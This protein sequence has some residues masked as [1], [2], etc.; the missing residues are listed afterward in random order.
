MPVIA[1]CHCGGTRIELPEPPAGLTACTCTYCTKSGGLWGYYKP[2]APVI[3][4]DEFGAVYSASD[5]INRHHFCVRCGCQTYGDSPDWSLDGA[6]GI[7][8]QRKFAINARLL[9][10]FALFRALPVTEIDGRT[11]W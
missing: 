6:E 2:E 5:G 10:D 1:T 7:P 4:S 3:V 9:D 8:T 11:L